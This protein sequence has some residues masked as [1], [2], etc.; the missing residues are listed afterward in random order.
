M[1]K[2]TEIEGS[3]ILI[4]GA[5]GQFARQVVAGYAKR[6]QIFAAARYAKQADFDAV[7]AI[8]ATPVRIDLSDPESLR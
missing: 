7:A 2:R 4:T 8:G 1:I 6:T 5:K 3:R